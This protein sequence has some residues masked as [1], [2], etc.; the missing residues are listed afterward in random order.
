VQG[1]ERQ[2]LDGATDTLKRTLAI[3]LEL[4]VEHLY[5]GGWT[6]T[7]AIQHLDKLGFAPA[8]FRTV[9]PLPDDHSSAFEFDCLFRRRRSH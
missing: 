9:V 5:D 8:Q 6:F 4:P 3:Y 2:V 7:E 1:F